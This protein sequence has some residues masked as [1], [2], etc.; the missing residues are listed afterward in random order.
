MQSG[1]CDV[2]RAT[3]RS[4]L[5]SEAADRVRTAS[6]ISARAAEHAAKFCPDEMGTPAEIVMRAEVRVEAASAR[7]DGKACLRWV[8]AV[9]GAL[10]GLP[11]YKTKPPV[12]DFDAG[13][14]ATAAIRCAGAA[15]YCDEAKELYVGMRVGK[16]STPD[17]IKKAESDFLSLG[18]AARE[19][20]GAAK[21]K[22]K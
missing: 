21:K 8:K 2:G 11:S 13:L 22:K 6:E 1:K 19:C 20:G 17:A 4:Y 9:Y 10:P 14:V 18:V 12:S 7:G 16:K 15:G 3:Y 5:E